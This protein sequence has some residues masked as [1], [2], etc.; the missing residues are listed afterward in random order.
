MAIHTKKRAIGSSAH[1]DDG[2]GEAPLRVGDGGLSRDGD[3][4]SH[5][6]D[7][8]PCGDGEPD[9]G[10]ERGVLSALQRWRCQLK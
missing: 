10:G 8:E 4:R 3:G 2:D 1:R 5:G 6:G 7:G 9:G